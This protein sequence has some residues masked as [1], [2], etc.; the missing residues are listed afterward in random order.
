[1]NQQG[2]DYRL[3]R[4]GVVMRADPGNPDEALGVLNPATARGPDGKL[5]L[6]ARVV[7]AGNYSRIGIA[8]V[9]SDAR[10]DPVRSSR[11]SPTSATRAPPA[12]K[13][14]ASRS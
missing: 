11:P 8:E 12:A 10:G 5:Y 4:L 13:T 9:L 7:A 3:H 14:R 2:S 1:M 6:F